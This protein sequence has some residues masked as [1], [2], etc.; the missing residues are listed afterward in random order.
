MVED[1]SEPMS[2]AHCTLRAEYGDPSW[3]SDATSIPST[4]AILDLIEFSYRHVAMPAKGSFHEY[5]DHTT[6]LR[7]RGGVARTLQNG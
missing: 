2:T 6:E 4:L 3:L 7:P 5:F 1:Q